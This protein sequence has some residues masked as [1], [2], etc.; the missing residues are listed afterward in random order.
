MKYVVDTCAINRIAD[1][2]FDPDSE[3]P[4]GS[5]F[6]ITHVQ[7]D[8][9]NN[10][11]DKD[12]ERRAQLSL[13]TAKLRPKLI[14]TESTAWDV[15]RW[16]QA[17]LGEGATYNDVRAALDARN[18]RKANNPQDALIA[19]SALKNGWTLLTADRDLADVVEDRGGTVHFIAAKK[20]PRS[21]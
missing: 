5:E 12:K 1:E 21:P 20:Q 2:L 7:Y 13:V 10:V 14:P 16:D 17:K 3:L 8:E 6:Y 9:L 15:T 4:A 19:E 11:P 18:R